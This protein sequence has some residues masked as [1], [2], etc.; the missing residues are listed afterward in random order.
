M[1]DAPPND[2]AFARQLAEKLKTQMLMETFKGKFYPTSVKEMDEH[3]KQFGP[4]LSNFELTH[5]AR[6]KIRRKI[7]RQ[8]KERE[9]KGE[10]TKKSW[11]VRKVGK[12]IVVNGEVVYPITWEE[13]LAQPSDLHDAIDTLKRTCPDFKKKGSDYIHE[14]LYR[15]QC[16]ND[17][18][19]PQL[20]EIKKEDLTKEEA[21]E[22][23]KEASKVIKAKKARGAKAHSGND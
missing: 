7:A 22:I 13:T 8:L 6:A 16:M 11:P 12:A 4:L 15:Q 2:K 1:S 10:T 23:I 19:N 3:Y 17:K 20:G 14:V 18:A 5:A 21:D 9:D